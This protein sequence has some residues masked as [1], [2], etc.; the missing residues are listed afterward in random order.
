MSNTS[1][2][3]NQTVAAFSPV[4]GGNSGTTI[5]VGAYSSGFSLCQI[6]PNGLS[7]S[8]ELQLTWNCIGNIQNSGSSTTAMTFLNNAQNQANITQ[9]LLT[10]SEA[11]DL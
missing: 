5:V 3:Y 9:Y 4:I 7:S 1:F 11:G 8:N 10:G 6:Q 2:P